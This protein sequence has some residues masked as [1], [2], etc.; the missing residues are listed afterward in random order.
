[1]SYYFSVLCPIRSLKNVQHCEVIWKD[2][3]V[4]F[5]EFRCKD[6]VASACFIVGFLRLFKPWLRSC[7]TFWFELFLSSIVLSTCAHTVGWACVVLVT[8]IKERSEDQSVHHALCFECRAASTLWSTSSPPTLST[9]PASPSP[10]L[11]SRYTL[12]HCPYLLLQVMFNL[13]CVQ[14]V[15]CINTSGNYQP[16]QMLMYSND[17]DFQA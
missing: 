5:Q 2:S 7:F 1:M 14:H 4:S 15:W 10:S 13:T 16:L 6:W 11:S 12:I 9:S 3:L 17:S 8:Y